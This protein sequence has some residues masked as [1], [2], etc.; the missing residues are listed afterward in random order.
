MQPII[1]SG[2]AKVTAVNVECGGHFHVH[3][4]PEEELLLTDLNS[5]TAEIFIPALEN[6]YKKFD[7]IERLF[8]GRSIPIDEA[9]INIAVVT[10]EE[11][12]KKEHALKKKTNEKK[13][14]ENTSESALRARYRAGEGDLGL[15]ETIYLPKK[16]IKLHELFFLDKIAQTVS[17]SIS[18]R[19]TRLLIEGRAGIGKSTLAKFLTYQW[20][21]REQDSEEPLIQAM[22]Q[23]LKAQFSGVVWI[24]LRHLN[25]N[26]YTLAQELSL[27]DLLRCQKGFNLENAT[28]INKVLDNYA[29]SPKP[30]FYILDGWDELDPSMWTETSPRSKLLEKL[31]DQPAWLITSRPGHIPREIK[32]DVH[33]ELLG[34]NPENVVRYIQ[35]FFKD[36]ER[37]GQACID[38]LLTFVKKPMI[39]GMAHIPI[40]LELLCCAWKDGR[41]ERLIS[42]EEISLAELYYEIVASL[43][44]RFHDGEIQKRLGVHQT[45]QIGSADQ[46]WPSYHNS[47][48]CLQALAFKAMQQKSSLFCLNEPCYRNILLDYQPTKLVED[49]TSFN[50]AILKFEGLKLLQDTSDKTCIIDPLKQHYYFVHSS[51]QEFLA[52]CYLMNEICSDK[53]TRREVAV[54]WISENKYFLR[55]RV[56]I[57]FLINLLTLEI[58]TDKL[59]LHNILGIEN[60]NSLQPKIIR[61]HQLFWSAIVEKHIDI[62]GIR[63]MELL[64]F[65]ASHMK[66][67]IEIMPVY[68]SLKRLVSQIIETNNR[69]YKYDK[70]LLNRMWFGRLKQALN[71]CSIN[72][73]GHLLSEQIENLS[74]LDKAKQEYA[75]IALQSI[76]AAAAIPEVLFQLKNLI[77]Q[78]MEV[79]YKAFAVLKTMGAAAATPEILSLL[80]HLLSQNADS[81]LEREV[82]RVLEIMGV[83]AAKTEILSLLALAV[84]KKN[85][86]ALLALRAMGPEAAINEIP[87]QLIEL[88]PNEKGPRQER[89]FDVLNAMGSAAAKREVLSLLV[90][91][92]KN[93]S[94]EV[95]WNALR[96]LEA[97]GAAANNSQVSI[98]L[99]HLITPP[100][101]FL[102]S[103]SN[104]HTT[105][106]GRQQ[107]KAL[108]W[109]A[110][111]VQTAIGASSPIFISTLINLAQSKNKEEQRNA[112][113]SLNGIGAAAATPELLSQL[114]TCMQKEDKVVQRN[115]LLILLAMGSVAATFEVLSQLATLVQSEDKKVQKS[116][117]DVL[118][119]MGAVAAEP[120]VLSQLAN[121]VQNQ[122]QEVQMSVLNVLQA[123]GVVAATPEVFSQLI[124]LVQAKNHLVVKNYALNFLFK[125]GI[126]VATPDILSQLV[127][128]VQSESGEKSEITINFLNDTNRSG[129]IYILNHY[130]VELHFILIQLLC[131]NDSAL[132]CEQDKKIQLSFI[133]SEEQEE[134]NFLDAFLSNYTAMLSIT[135][136]RLGNPDKLLMT[137]AQQLK[138]NREQLHALNQN[139]IDIEETMGSW[140]ISATRLYL[141]D[142]NKASFW[143]SPPVI[144]GMIVAGVAV[145]VAVTLNVESLQDMCKIQ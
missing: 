115:A 72:V 14:P 96:V 66:Q 93:H 121:L 49:I 99:S 25:Q 91:L 87:L 18:S 3:L 21:Q 85:Q 83:A 7:S 56:V 42:G 141:V 118:L 1:A 57:G 144:A 126:S 58:E 10:S 51:F 112:L 81:S 65:L 15:Y 143:Q 11:Q 104:E 67:G 130:N 69:A 46:L 35:I 39:A 37:V 4:S 32:K 107:N 43:V 101:P 100:M 142:K 82:F 124:N 106:L 86:H 8:E 119:A 103:R 16:E 55:Y 5:Y 78:N 47:L 94:G 20:S 17:S 139:H 53:E 31:I 84:Q 125:T 90:T 98:C 111:Q 22:R 110:F 27:T 44:K 62:I 64:F 79:R 136:E 137:T 60:K 113:E 48:V 128:L 13:L 63:Q 23:A 6:T 45:G 102:S 127:N 108:Q 74:S 19:A 123:M 68:A 134:F 97:M 24:S 26:R 40:N 29:K 120:V 122:D 95:Q 34:F 33:L 41:S 59:P 76:G 89:I 75:F 114:L 116:A 71:Y 140:L 12:C 80:E 77:M 73:R 133:D 9:F 38:K 30:L 117:L 138:Q 28:I 145:G 132:L 54:N 61:A 92:I 135:S 131:Q 109:R 105:F 52:A 88:L 36:D 129:I 50:Q 70:F 2:N